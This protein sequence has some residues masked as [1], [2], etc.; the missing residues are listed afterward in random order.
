MAQKQEFLDA[1]GDAYFDR[2]PKDADCESDPVVRALAPLAIKPKM[3]LEIG[4]GN[5][6]RL[7]CVTRLIGGTGHGIEP[8]GKAVEFATREFPELKVVQGTAD[9]LPYADGQ[10]DLV[11]FGFCLYLC[12]P[13][14]HFRIAWQADRVLK[15][16]GFVVIKD[17]LPPSPFRNAYAHKPGVRSYKMDWSTMFTWHPAY[18]LLTRH[19][20]EHAKPFTFHPNERICIDVLRK[21]ATVA[22][23]DNPYR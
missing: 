7:A 10:F 13:Q 6:A 19:Y 12:D 5:G 16:T 17:F 11:I 22:F 4:C 14:D 15:E 18:R 3:V 9:D 8:S 20:I 21:D 23:P 2:N 1:E